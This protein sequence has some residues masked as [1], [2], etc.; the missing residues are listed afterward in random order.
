[1]STFSFNLLPKKSKQTID[2]EVKRDSYSVYYSLLVLLGVMMWLGLLLFNNFVVDSKRADWELSNQ[3]KTEKINNEYQDIREL[4]GELVIKTNS[5][6][7]LL[8][9]DV[10][11][12]VIFLVADEVFPSN[13]QGIEI[14][15]YGRNDDGSFSISVAASDEL[16]IAQ[17][18]R[19]LRE[20]PLVKELQ[21]DTVNYNQNANQL[22]ANFNFDINLEQL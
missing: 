3:R 21:V 15:G 1:M 20:L 17:K 8:I 11:P 2:R 14:V 9:K 22:I 19:S 4:H 5:L 6:E 13:E 16:L 12:E 7:P 18:A 10:D